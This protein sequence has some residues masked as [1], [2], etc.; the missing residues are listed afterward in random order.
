MF[1]VPLAKWYPSS[2]L[3]K[4]YSGQS[5]NMQIDTYRWTPLLR[6]SFKEG[7]GGGGEEE[8]SYCKLV[9]SYS[10]SDVPIS[11]L[12]GLLSL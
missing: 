1:H 7:D 8:W 2:F 10:S 11:Q 5:K 6:G 12:F 3:T 4:S 9:D